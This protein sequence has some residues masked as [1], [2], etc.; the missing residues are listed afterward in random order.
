MHERSSHCILMRESG[1][2][3]IGIEDFKPFFRHVSSIFIYN[4]D[5]IM[6]TLEGRD[7]M[8]LLV[9][10]MRKV[11]D[12]YPD[13][14]EDVY[15]RHRSECRFLLPLQNNFN[16]VTSL[17]ICQRNCFVNIPR[18]FVTHNTIAEMEC[19]FILKDNKEGFPPRRGWL[20]IL[21][22]PDSGIRDIPFYVAF[23]LYFPS[24]MELICFD[25]WRKS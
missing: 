5:E 24:D 25:Q 23:L 19:R 13:I 12:E 8:F 15:C 21:Q 16:K 1:S 4:S 2:S 22:I 10:P 14:F 6:T 20:R 18:G 3:I 7:R 9:N 17:H 11:E